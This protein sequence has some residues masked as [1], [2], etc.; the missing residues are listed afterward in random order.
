MMVKDPLTVNRV[1]TRDELLREDLEKDLWERI[2]IL[3]EKRPVI[4]TLKYSDKHKKLL[5][6]VLLDELKLDGE[7][8]LEEEMANVEMVREYKAIKEKKDPGVFVLPIH[9]EAKFDYHSLVDIGSN[10]NVMPYRI[11]EK[12][13]REQVKPVSNGISMLD[14]SKAEP[15]GILKDVLCQVGVTTVLAKFLILDIPVD[16]DVPFVVGRSFLHTCGGIINTIKG[17]TLIFDDVCHQK[18]FVAL[19]RNNHGEND[20]E[21]EEEYC[22]KRDK[23][24]KPFYGPNRASYLNS[25]DPMDRALALQEALDHFKKIYVWKKSIAFLGSLPVPLQYQEWRPS[26]LGNIAKESGDGKW[27]TKIRIMECKT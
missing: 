10:I 23:M 15:M 11:F 22:L 2:I 25:E 19:V 13:G 6:S 26:R 17:T 9:L 18:F 8:E 21:D 5:D 24:G 1:L 16:H 20:S 3:S 4:E 14:H 27:H 7:L 12:L